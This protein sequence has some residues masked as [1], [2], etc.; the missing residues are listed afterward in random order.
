MAA[1]I[2][3]STLKKLKRYWAVKRGPWK[4]TVDIGAIDFPGGFR[5]P[6]KGTTNLK[7]T[8]RTGGFYLPYAGKA[9]H[10][11]PDYPTGADYN[12]QTYAQQYSL[13]AKTFIGMD[14]RKRYW[15]RYPLFTNDPEALQ[16]FDTFAHKAEITERGFLTKFVTNH[17]FCA[18]IL[19]PEY[20]LLDEGGYKYRWQLYL[21]DYNY[22]DQNR[23]FTSIDLEAISYQDA[24]TYAKLAPCAGINTTPEIFIDDNTRMSSIHLT[25]SLSNITENAKHIAQ[26]I[27]RLIV[28]TLMTQ[29]YTM[30][31]TSKWGDV[32]TLEDTIDTMINNRLQGLQADLDSPVL[33]EVEDVTTTK[34]NAYEWEKDSL[35]LK[36]SKSLSSLKKIPV[37]G[38]LFTK[39]EKKSEVMFLQR[40]NNSDLTRKK[41]IYEMQLYMPKYLKDQ[42]N[43]E[44]R[45]IKEIVWANT[46]KATAALIAY[47]EGTAE[48]H[49]DSK[50]EAENPFLVFSLEDSKTVGTPM[51]RDI[52]KRPFKIERPLIKSG[53]VP[54]SAYKEAERRAIGMIRVQDAK[55]RWVTGGPEE[56]EKSGFLLKLLALGAGG[57]FLY[58]Q[59]KG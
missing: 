10:I 13:I 44:L 6:A 29:I 42:I 47:E 35:M 40:N 45:R 50:D 3:I 34:G 49:E 21:I 57:F 18:V 32:G 58:N 26:S 27:R 54:L 36:T 17:P 25:T 14:I 56:D 5:E 43:S 16:Y 55:G 59:V 20:V 7:P 51:F 52:S 30:L 11:E 4:K 28:S 48:P 15:D 23:L 33:V 53:R 8:H 12:P 1:K 2:E 46:I 19:H 37:S 9:Y 41:V 39:N 31:H 22:H 38:G 24:I